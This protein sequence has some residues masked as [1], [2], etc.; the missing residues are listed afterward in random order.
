MDVN[1]LE[2]R[3]YSSKRPKEW[4]VLYTAS[5]AEKIAE[6]RLLEENGVEVYLPLYMS[7]RK[8]SDRVK[9][10]ELPL[11]NS[12][13]FVYCT[14]IKLRMLVGIPGI[15]RIVYYDKKPA[16]VKN[17]E[18]DAI[19]EFVG[20]AKGCNIISEGDVVDILGGPFEKVSG[21][22]LRLNDKIVTLSIDTLGTIC[23]Q[24]EVELDK[25]VK[26]KTKK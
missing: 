9:I 18:I 14:E 5:R 19:K 8:W 13:I 11:F 1:N 22:V 24:L 4:F 3:P 26:K 25:V 16:I 15:A 12:Y 20:I 7:K 21:K 23:M 17:F 6:K 2:T 10:V